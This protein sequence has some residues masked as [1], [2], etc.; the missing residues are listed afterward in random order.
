MLEVGTGD[1][2]VTRIAAGAVDR[3]GGAGRVTL[4]R[5]GDKHEHETETRDHRDAFDAALRLMDE[6]GCLSDI[7]A[8]GH[9]IVHGGLRFR[10]STVIDANVI[11]AIREVS[12]LAPL[13][14]APALA[15]IEA[16]GAAFGPEVPMVAAFDTA[17]FADLPDV[18]SRYAI[19]KE[20]S[21][22]YG[23]RRFGFH[24]L[25][26]DDMIRRFQTLRP[27]VPRPRLVTLQ[28]G[29][30][31]SAT[32]SFEGRPVDTSMGYTPLEGLIMGTRSGDLDP[33][34]PL[35]LQALTGMSAQDVEDL[36][37]SRS[38]LL[39]LSGRSADMRDLLEAAASG[40]A[41][42]ALAVDAFCAR[43][44]KYVGAYTALLGGIDALIFGGGI[45]EH[46]PEI[47]RR[48]CRGMQWAGLTLDEDANQ[49]AAG[50]EVHISAN[51]SRIDVWVMHV[52]EAAVIA[53]ETV[54]L[55]TGREEQPDATDR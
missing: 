9:R 23:I 4:E 10:S 26:H 41:D 55:L 18:A 21:E 47:R 12:D 11:G 46:S 49:I 33:A 53:R 52:D 24:G 28:L 37:N 36:L 29:N 51:A 45:G 27:E 48:I 34:L 42:C 30:G 19:P 6:A 32:A 31:C 39:G 7:A 40:D 20:L 14:N 54:A 2:E 1:A 43:T 35:R 3:I 13:H 8:I 44:T 38:G 5:D 16:A 17:F 15:V 25:A 50:P 22:R